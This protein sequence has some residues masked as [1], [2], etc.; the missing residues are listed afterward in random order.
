MQND[1]GGVAIQLAGTSLKNR[2]SR[3]HR[4]PPPVHA[5]S[6]RLPAHLVDAVEHQLDVDVTAV[7][8]QFRLGPRA[9]GAGLDDGE[10]LLA[11]NRVLARPSAPRSVLR[12]NSKERANDGCSAR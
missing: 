11:L 7:A 1:P 12:R 6:H 4:N 10:N 2:M 9:A 5:F 3:A 8:F